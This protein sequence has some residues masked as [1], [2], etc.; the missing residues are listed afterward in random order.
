MLGAVSADGHPIRGAFTFAVGQRSAVSGGIAQGAFGNT[1][2]QSLEVIGAI[3]RFVAYVSTLGACG[4]VLV[5]GRLRHP[6]E[7]TPVGRNVA[8]A[9]A[10][11]VVALAVQ[12]VTLAALA[13]GEGY[14]SIA[15][16]GVLALVL[17]EGFGATALIALVALLGI[18]ITVGLPFE[19]AARSIAVTGAAVAPLSMVLYGHTRRSIRLWHEERRR[20]RAT[21]PVGPISWGTG[22]GRRLPAR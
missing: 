13:T 2:D 16:P 22:W 1:D 20:S 3:A 15:Q 17:D 5:G 8:L 11:A 12:L 6:D 18:T 19:G 7:P 14:G 9:L 4:A 10:A 21:L